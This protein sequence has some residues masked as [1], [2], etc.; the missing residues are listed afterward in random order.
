MIAILR[1][2]ALTKTDKLL[3]FIKNLL[4]IAAQHLD[5]HYYLLSMGNY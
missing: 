3:L 1:N 5:T 2:L 4:I